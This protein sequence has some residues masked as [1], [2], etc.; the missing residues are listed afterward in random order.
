MA[1][2]VPLGNGHFQESR[3]TPMGR[4]WMQSTGQGSKQSS[5]PVH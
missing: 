3:P 1:G 5:Q 4:I 2:D